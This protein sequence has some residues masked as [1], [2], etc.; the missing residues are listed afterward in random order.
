MTSELV[1]KFVTFA[2]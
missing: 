2:W 1:L